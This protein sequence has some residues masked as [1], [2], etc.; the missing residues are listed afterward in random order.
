M[1]FFGDAYAVLYEAAVFIRVSSFG[2][3]HALTSLEKIAANSNPPSPDLVG[4]S[5]D[6]TIIR[7]EGDFMF[8]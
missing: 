7:C 5:H 3:S 1:S 4:D 8:F 6:Q 2:N